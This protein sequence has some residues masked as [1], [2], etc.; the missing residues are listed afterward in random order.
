MKE[1]RLHEYGPIQGVGCTPIPGDNQALS[2][3]MQQT[4]R[5]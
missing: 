5:K 1:E 3:I 2:W 4:I